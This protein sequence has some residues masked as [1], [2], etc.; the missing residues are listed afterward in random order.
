MDELED[1]IAVV[2]TLLIEL[3]GLVDPGAL[4]D[5][6]RS[7]RERAAE[8]IEGRERAV[9]L[10]AAQLAEDAARRWAPPFG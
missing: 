7:L 3:L 6:A 1:R 10:G 2:E 8:D 4:A 5:A 9:R